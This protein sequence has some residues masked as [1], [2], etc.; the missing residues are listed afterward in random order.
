MVSSANVLFVLLM[1]L[2]PL[3]SVSSSNWIVCWAGMELS[4]LGLIPLF[5]VGNKFISFNKESALK[6]FCI[7]AV[8]SALLLIAGLGFFDMY[9]GG[10]MTGGLLILSLCIKLGVFPGHFWVPPVVSGLETMSCFLVLSIQKI[11]PLGLLVKTLSLMPSGSQEFCLLLGGVSAVVGSL[12]GNNQTQVLPMI[13][14]SSITHTSW[15]MLGSVS[16]S[17]WV[18]F[19]LYCFVLGMTLMYLRWGWEMASCL[20]LL[21]LSGLPPFLMFSGKWSVIKAGIDSSISLFFLGLFLLGALFSLI[22]YLKF[23]YSFYLSLKN[24]AKLMGSME[25]L[26]FVLINFLGAF[27]VVIL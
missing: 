24:R 1:I 8:G 18:Y 5:F 20:S 17:L 14:A 12:I 9:N 25:I 13:G 7:Q 11:P 16:G 3:V 22:F 19:S 26:S 10:F 4:F 27:L 21:S 2:G 15:L 23:S 6:Y